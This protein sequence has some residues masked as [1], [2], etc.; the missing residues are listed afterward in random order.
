MKTMDDLTRKALDCL[1]GL[2]IDSLIYV[3][4]EEGRRCYKAAS[5]EVK[6][7]V[8]VQHDR[9]EFVEDLERGYRVQAYLEK[10][11]FPTNR[12]CFSK[13]GNLVQRCHGYG[14]VVEPWIER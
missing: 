1:W 6:L 12:I 14:I 4:E 3:D 13:E 5:G 7:F 11:G 9:D 8:K 10:N 2:N